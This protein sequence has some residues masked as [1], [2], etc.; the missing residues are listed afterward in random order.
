M[1]IY[2]NI[3]DITE[4]NH[5]NDEIQIGLI[6]SENMYRKDELQRQLTKLKADYDQKYINLQA[7]FEL[8]KQSILNAISVINSVIKD[9]KI[10]I[11]QS[12]KIAFKRKRRND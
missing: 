8:K 6:N 5:Y 1:D 7:D 12:L 10:S 2:T 9:P 4:R 3:Q 11:L